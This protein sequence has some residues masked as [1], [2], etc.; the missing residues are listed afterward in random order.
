MDFDEADKI[1]SNIREIRKQKKITIQKLSPFTKLSVDCLRNPE[2]SQT[3]LIL[4]TLQKSC[5]APFLS[6]RDLLL[7][8]EEEQIIFN[9]NEQR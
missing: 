3:S 5:I 8:P 6:L 2:R 1:G 4:N 7:L 9:W